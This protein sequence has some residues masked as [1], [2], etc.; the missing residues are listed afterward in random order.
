MYNS[1]IVDCT[2]SMIVC[3]ARRMQ[4]HPT[5]DSPYHTLA[6]TT[7]L[8]T[9]SLHKKLPLETTAIFLSNV[10][11]SRVYDSASASLAEGAG[12]NPTVGKNYYILILEL[13]HTQGP[14]RNI[15]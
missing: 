11:L 4:I 14:I 15:I 7:G 2:L 5:Q 10:Y 1:D 3:D 12:S 13:G 8:H 6:M 9:Y